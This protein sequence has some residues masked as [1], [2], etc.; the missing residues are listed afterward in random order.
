MDYRIFALD[1]IGDR[2]AHAALIG[3]SHLVYVLCRVSQFSC[4]CSVCNAFHYF[5][6]IAAIGSSHFLPWILMVYTC[7][8][9]I[10][11]LPSADIL[12]RGPRLHGKFSTLPSKADGTIFT[13]TSH[14]R[15]VILISKC[16]HWLL[17]RKVCVSLPLSS[18][19]CPPPKCTTSLSRH[20]TAFFVPPQSGQHL[21][22]ILAFEHLTLS[23]FENFELGVF[24]RSV[25]CHG[26]WKALGDKVTFAT[27]TATDRNGKCDVVI[28]SCSNDDVASCKQYVS[29]ENEGESGWGSL[30]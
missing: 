30:C 2:F 6:H 7:Y 9:V 8:T 13:K 19:L 17:R 20:A 4:Y 24:E 23:K 16:S 29:T 15:S 1:S 18:C 21:S 11:T 12:D 10:S 14:M 5:T 26:V 22:H 3:F 27:K 28:R 25:R